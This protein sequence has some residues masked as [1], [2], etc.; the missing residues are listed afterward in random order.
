MAAHSKVTA[1]FQA[2]ASISGAANTA[3]HDDVKDEVEKEVERK[4]NAAEQKKRNAARDAER[5]E[6]EAAAKFQD[7]R[8]SPQKPKTA[9]QPQ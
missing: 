2:G 9:G 1:Q 7:S 3:R 4:V 5:R 8:P 6:V